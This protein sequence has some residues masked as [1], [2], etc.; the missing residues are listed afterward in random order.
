MVYAVSKIA[1]NPVGHVHAADLLQP[2][3]VGDIAFSF[4]VSSFMI[5]HWTVIGM[6]RLFRYNISASITQHFF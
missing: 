1:S 4:V 3:L 6:T 2:Q 5:P